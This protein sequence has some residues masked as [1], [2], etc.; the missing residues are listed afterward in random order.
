MFIAECQIFLLHV[1]CIYGSKVWLAEYLPLT[2]H[3]CRPT[4]ICISSSKVWLAGA[5]T[6]VIIAGVYQLV[7]C[8]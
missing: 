3:Y 6:S 7:R 1:L 2:V 8:G 4:C 5:S